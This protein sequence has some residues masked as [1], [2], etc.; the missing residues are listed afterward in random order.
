[1]GSTL[2]NELGL[3]RI[4]D[5]PHIHGEHLPALRAYDPAVGSPPYTWGAHEITQI[6]IQSY[7]ITPIYMGST[8]PALAWPLGQRDHPH[9]HGEHARVGGV[10]KDNVGSPPYTWGAPEIIIVRR[11][12]GGITPIYMGSTR[13]G[14]AL[15]IK[16]KDH[17]HIHGEH[18][19]YKPATSN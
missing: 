3:T 1:M 14:L 13:Q 15:A 18:F 4:W 11:V 10:D 2:N 17:P 16:V 7:G 8:A 19:T 9:I 5:H 6:R 12:P